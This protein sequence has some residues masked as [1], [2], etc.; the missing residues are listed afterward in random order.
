MTNTLPVLAVSHLSVEF[1][2]DAG[3][4][5]AV[6]DLSWDLHAGETLAIVGESGSG[7]SVSVR[8]IIRLLPDQ[9][10]RIAAD[11]IRLNDIELAGASDDTLQAVRGSEVAIV[12]QDPSAALNPVY[13]IGW[14]IAE[15]FRVQTGAS[16]RN[17][18]KQAVELLGRVGIPNPSV[19]AREYPHQMSSGMRQRSLIAMAVALEPSVL[20]ADE[21]TTA[22]D[23]TV[24][25]E[26]MELL[27][28]LQQETGMGLVLITHDL[29]IA[30]S[31]ADHI[32]VMYGGRA[33]ESAPADRFYHQPAHPYSRGLLDSV[34]RLDTPLESMRPIPGAPPS[35]LHLPDGCAFHPRCVWANDSCRSARPQ[36]RPVGGPRAGPADRGHESACIKADQLDLR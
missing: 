27:S 22:L 29:G 8:A 33:V 24:Q 10:G 14:Q 6:T 17:A 19:R 35:P 3:V 7:K 36:L 28:D 11:S 15:T 5:A 12:F 23:V 9:R 32:L 25:A 1:D 26:I 20:I 18:Q 4:V 13:T 30:S 31:V 21:P 34:P 16:R 2:T